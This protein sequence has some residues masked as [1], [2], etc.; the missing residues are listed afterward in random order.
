MMLIAILMM[1][2]GAILWLGVVALEL[3]FIGL[4]IAFVMWVARGFFRMLV[5]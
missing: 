2:G 3:I 1:I 5:N 4:A